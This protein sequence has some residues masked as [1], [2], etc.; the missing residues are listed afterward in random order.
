MTRL[1]S[2]AGCSCADVLVRCTATD[3]LGWFVGV[4][5]VVFNG[6][7]SRPMTSSSS[8]HR[9]S[10]CRYQRLV[11]NGCSDRDCRCGC[12][13]VDGAEVLFGDGSGCRLR[14]LVKEDAHR[15]W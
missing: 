4:G 7:E 9:D 11:A 13:K 12:A 14:R 6:E 8:L 2:G 5:N 10:S 1:G 15:H 3:H